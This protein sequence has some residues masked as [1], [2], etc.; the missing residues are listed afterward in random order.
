[1]RDRVIQYILNGKRPEAC[2]DL[3]RW[4]RWIETA[5]RH[6]ASTQIGDVWVS[7]VFIGLD[8]NFFGEG[9]PVLFETLAF[10]NHQSAETLAFARYSTWEEAEAGHGAAVSIA[11]AAI[12]ASQERGC[13][14]MKLMQEEWQKARW[15]PIEP[16]VRKSVERNI[17]KRKKVEQ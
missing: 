4:A 15:K 11:K 9:P 17:R 6:V 16:A 2:G 14:F 3:L 5:E 7:T 12:A 13:A 1:M 8:H 10:V